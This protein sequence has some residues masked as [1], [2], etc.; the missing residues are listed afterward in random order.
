[1]SFVDTRFPQVERRLRRQARGFS[2][3]SDASV[4]NENHLD[5]QFRLKF[6]ERMRPDVKGF[7]YYCWKPHIIGRRLEELEDGDMLVYVD[8]GAHLNRFGQKTLQQYLDICAN[9]PSGILGFQTKWIEKEWNKGDLLRYFQVEKDPIITDTG[10]IQSGTLIIRN[11]PNSRGFVR[12]WGQLYW[13]N[14]A[15]TD[16]SPSKSKNLPGFRKHRHDQSV[17][18][19]LGKKAGIEILPAS[20]SEPRFRWIGYWSSLDKPIHHRRHIPGHASR[21]VTN[22]VRPLKEWLDV[23]VSLLSTVMLRR[24]G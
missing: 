2:I 16:D 14:F 12:A 3:I 18:S 11:S 19:I 7:G 6:S 4:M 15:L 24:K 17:L 8:A 13:S 22:R 5:E 21:R 20:E 23:Q 1:M 9:S 10:Q